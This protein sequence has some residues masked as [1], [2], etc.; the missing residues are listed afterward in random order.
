MLFRSHQRPRLIERMQRY[1]GIHE[2]LE[3]ENDQDG[4]KSGSRVDFFACDLGVRYPVLEA[5]M[6]R[7]L[8]H[9][10]LKV[11]YFSTVIRLISIEI[12]LYYTIITLLFHC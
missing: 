10:R 9:V 5:A 7:S 8:L 1:A 11:S 3:L 6:K 2:E 12:L 4:P